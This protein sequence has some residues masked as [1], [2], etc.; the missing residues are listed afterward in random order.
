[1][2][3][4]GGSSKTPKYKDPLKTPPDPNVG[5]FEPENTGPIRRVAAEQEEGDA[6]QQLL[7]G[8][9]STPDDDEALRR[10][11]TSLIG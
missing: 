2:G 3:F 11:Q 6:S 10:K 5:K 8:T 1:M 4:G 9:A 7:S